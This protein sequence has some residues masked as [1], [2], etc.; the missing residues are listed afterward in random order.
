MTL[1]SAVETD[2]AAA[3]DMLLTT[4]PKEYV[5]KVVADNNLKEL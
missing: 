2:V 5:I 3:V 1:E 4:L